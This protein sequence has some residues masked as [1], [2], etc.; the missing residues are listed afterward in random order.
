MAQVPH[1]DESRSKVSQTAFGVATF[2]ALETA[3]GSDGGALIND[4]FASLFSCPESADWIQSLAL[5]PS[6]FDSMVTGIGIRTLKIDQEIASALHQAIDQVVVL[7]AGLDCRPWRIHNNADMKDIDMNRV[8]WYEI[9][10]SEVFDYKLSVLATSNAETLFQY[11]SVAANAA[12]D[13]W[14]QKLQEAGYDASKPAIWLLEGFTGYLTEE[15]LSKTIEDI[16]SHTAKNS[17]LIATFLGNDFFAATSMHRF[18]TDKPLEFLEK[19]SWGNGKQEE[20]NQICKLH[21][22][23]AHGENWNAYYFVVASLIQCL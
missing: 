16:V 22:R 3:K 20:M 18:L 15:E 8:K 1:H 11:R 4:P 12:V 9:D 13:N 7:G 14:T 5:S 2:R 23:E 17:V 19:W 21:N 10:F 6:Q